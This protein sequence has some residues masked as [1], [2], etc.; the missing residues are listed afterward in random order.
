MKTKLFL[1]IIIF[2]TII[3]NGQNIYPEGNAGSPIN[4]ADSTG[5]WTTGGILTTNATDP[6]SGTLAL[7]FESV[8]T[9]AADRRISYTFNATIGETYNISIWAKGGEIMN[10]PAFA[11]WQDLTGF[12][13]P[14]NITSSTWAEYTFTVTADSTSPIIRIYSN[15]TGVA[16]IGSS[17]YIDSITITSSAT[18]TEAPTAIIDLTSTNTDETSTDLSWSASTDNVAV[19]DYEVFQDAVSIGNT[20][21][22]T[23]FNIDN[24][25]PGT[26]YD[27]TVF[28]EDAAGNVSLVSNTET[29]TTLADTEAPST[30]VDLIA[31]NTDETST[32]LSWSAS[33]DNVGV[34]GYEIFQDTG[35]IGT[36]STTTFDVSGLSPNTSYDFTVFALDGSGNSSLVSNIVNITTLADTEAP[37][38]ITDLLSSNITDTSTDL[39]WT[40]ST[41]NI[42]VTNYEVFQDGG[43][44][45]TT[46]G[47]ITFTVTG[48]S[49]ITSYDFTVVAIDAANNTSLISNTETITTADV[50]AP[51]AITDLSASGTTE[52]ET[53][54]TWSASTDNDSILN[55]EVFQNGQSIGTTIGA[56]TTFN[57][58][59]LTPGVSYDFTVY[60]IDPSNNTS[61]ISNTETV[62][63]L[64]DNTLPSTVSD[65]SAS[66]TTGTTT[67]LT[68]TLATDNI[69]VSDYRLY[70]TD[71]DNGANNTDFLIGSTT[72]PYTVTGL[73]VG[74]PYNLTIAAV[75]VAGNTAL[76][77]N[78]ANITTT[79]DN[80]APDIPTNL[81]AANTTDTTT[82]LIWTAS[83]ASDTNEYRVYQ[84]GG[85][86]GTT[87]SSIT[88]LSVSGLTASSTYIFN[89]TAVDLSLNE[90]GFSNSAIVTTSETGSGGIPYTDLNANLDTVDWTTNELFANGNVGIGINPQ[91]GYSLAVA[92]NIIAEEV[93]VA[94]QGN[95]PDYVFEKNY[96]LPSL[97]EVEN[98][99]NKHGHLENIPSAYDT[100]TNGIS[101]GE[102]NAKLLRKVEELTLYIIQQEKK[103]NELS[104]ENNN[105]K[106]LSERLSEIEQTLKEL[107]K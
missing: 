74:T 13:N 21:G 5:P 49:E 45:G 81:L 22:T 90:S 29:V 92:G 66:N 55:Y 59:S 88:M 16:N 76:E 33:T 79:L 6:Q 95:W 60:A 80:S 94:L 26:S 102:M 73:N 77:S 53:N 68:W 56:V 61:T 25:T 48:L 99:I 7:R 52:T 36:T 2:C 19:T 69:G 101:V 1:L 18:D 63:T 44:I 86:I 103:I 17:V 98:Y 12:T 70:I 40:A 14:T 15:G 72:S 97:L 64:S 31:S 20:G 85:L 57:V 11:V 87:S 8:S 32:D 50:T 105:L 3:T 41:D 47:A 30:I 39:S 35:I 23:T 71:L 28:A 24:L 83:N 46:G 91:A 37:S 10:A 93:R 34:T 27:Y 106:S 107:K 62:V 67:E 42:A 65:L 51:S 84:N 100:K 104:E 82:D 38:T 4:E 78:I 96:N 58:T 54:L 89:V 9:D 75:D 43:S